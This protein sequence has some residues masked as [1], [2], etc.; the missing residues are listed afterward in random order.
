[1]QIIGEGYNN[2]SILKKLTRGDGNTYSYISRQTLRHHIVKQ[3][4]CDDTPIQLIGKGKNKVIQFD[5]NATIKEYPE[6]DLFGYLKTNEGKT[7]CTRSAVVRLSNAI[8]LEEFHDDIDFLTNNG[9][10]QRYNCDKSINSIVQNEIHKSYYSYTIAIDLD[11]IGVDG[12]I[13]ISE[14][15]KKNRIKNFLKIIEFLYIDI[16][17]RRENLFP[18]FIIGGIYDIK[19]PFFENM[20]KI[21]NNKLNTKMLK[22]IIELDDE[23]IK[24]TQVG[25]IE[26]KFS[27]DDEIKKDLHPIRID[28]FFNNLIKKIE[29]DC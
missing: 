24:N 25:Y 16:R 27:N 6:I 7:A 15:E 11:E 28:E 3:M 8:S 17:G 19:S 10:A 12:E 1:M 18:F 2:I 9:L 21:S 5:P 26:S 13:N 22:N 14:N 4:H 23:I 29:E 20:I